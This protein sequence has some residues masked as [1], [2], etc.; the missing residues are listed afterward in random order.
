VAGQASIGIGVL[1]MF[2]LSAT[3]YNT[4]LAGWLAA[5][6]I[7]INFWVFLAAISLPIIIGCLLIWKFAL[8]S[9]YSS[10]NEQAYRHNNPL[11]KDIESVKDDARILKDDTKMLKSEL[12]LARADDHRILEILKRLAEKIGGEIEC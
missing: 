1:N 11:R 8:P 4:T 5:I 12:E 7:Y 6:G 9:F 3:A 10:A 2:M